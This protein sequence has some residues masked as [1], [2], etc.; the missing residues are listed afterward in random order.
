M[1]FFHGNLEDIGVASS[2]LQELSSGL[3]I[4]ILAVEYPGY[5]LYPG[6]K[7]PDKLLEDSLC[8]YDF[9]NRQVGVAEQDI[10]LYG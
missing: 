5:G 4:S 3:N 1:I 2:F 10:I 9:I 7:S 8:V 6:E